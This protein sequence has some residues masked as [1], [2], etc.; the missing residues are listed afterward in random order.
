MDKLLQAVLFLLLLLGA[1]GL[2]GCAP[3]E[4]EPALDL[5]SAEANIRAND[6]G[7][8]Q[9]NAMVQVL[10][11]GPESAGTL[12][13][14]FADRDE[15]VEGWIQGERGQRLIELEAQMVAAANARDLAGVKRTTGEAK[16]LR[17]ELRQLI[18]DHEEAILGTLTSEQQ[19]QWKGYEVSRKMLDLMKPLNLAFDQAQAIESAG[20]PAVF[21][22]IQRGEPT[23]KAAA[24]LDLEQWVEGQVLDEAQRAKYQNI[25]SENKVAEFGDLTVLG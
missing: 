15:A 22:A 4:E 2:P 9:Y 7:G 18:A 3:A 21:E 12:Q 19:V 6:T 8:E 20:A 10:A 5:A 11:L 14:A 25:K 24:F 16:P 23:P 1:G 17:N 13:R